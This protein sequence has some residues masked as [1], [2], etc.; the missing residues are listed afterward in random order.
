[1]KYICILSEHFFAF[2]RSN[3]FL[4]GGLTARYAYSVSLL[5]TKQIPCAPTLGNEEEVSY[6]PIGDVNPGELR[7][8][9]KNKYE[10]ETSR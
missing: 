2:S 8:E 5:T 6:I 4:D 9:I 10:K 1:L 3:L 7:Q